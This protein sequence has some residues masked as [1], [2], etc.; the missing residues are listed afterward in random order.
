MITE[1]LS[2]RRASPRPSRRPPWSSCPCRAPSRGTASA[3]P[4][5]GAG[6]P[7]GGSWSVSRLSCSL[8]CF[9]RCLDGFVSYD[10][11]FPDTL[12]RVAHLRQIQRGTDGVGDP[13]QA[14]LA[15]R[16]AHAEELA[17]RDIGVLHGVFLAMLPPARRALQ[18][19]RRVSLRQAEERYFFFSQ[20]QR[21][22]MNR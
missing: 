16:K 22:A 18:L 14:S 2:P 4:A 6:P 9:H 8:S 5:G 3:S 19:S 11:V 17:H 10:D 7:T 1:A 15:H 20:R 12:F 13:G 21:Q